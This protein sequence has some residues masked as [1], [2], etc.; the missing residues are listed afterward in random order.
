MNGRIG[1]E[2]V[3]SI[4]ISKDADFLKVE[5]YYQNQIDISFFKILSF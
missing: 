1:S 5:N 3:V 4:L 2:F